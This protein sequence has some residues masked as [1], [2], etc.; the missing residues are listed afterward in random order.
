MLYKKTVV[1]WLAGL[2][3]KSSFQ[4]TSNEAAERAGRQTTVL[5]FWWLGHA[6]TARIDAG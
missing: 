3:S 5:S 1:P 6:E 2:V 4:G